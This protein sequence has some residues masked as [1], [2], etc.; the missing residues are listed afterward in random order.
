MTATF[1]L[2][3]PQ[4]MENKQISVD[5]TIP[6]GQSSVSKEFI[7]TNGFIPRVVAYTNG[8]EK[9]TKEMIQL[10]LYDNAGVEIVSAVNI[11]NW[12]QNQ[13]EYFSSMKPLGIEGQGRTFKLILSTD[14]NLAQNPPIAI[15]PKV[16]V[17]FLYAKK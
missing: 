17:V 16:Q 2:K 7:L 5:L 4:K 8:I 12:E 14:R 13:G 1:F 6:Q 10:A 3:H 15:T 11:K 9:A